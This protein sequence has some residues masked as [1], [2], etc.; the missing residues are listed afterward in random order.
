MA[1]VHRE[2]SSG[3]GKKR[4][5]GRSSAVYTGRMAYACDRRYFLLAAGTIGLIQLSC[6]IE[7]W[8]FKF[9]RGFHHFW[10]VALVE[11][12]IF[13]LCGHVATARKLSQPILELPRK[14]SGP[15]PLYA[16]VGFCLAGGTGLGKLA[17][18]YL[19]Y[20]TGTILKSMKLLP[21]LMLSACWL[22]RRFHRL[23]VMASVLM[24]GSAA[25]FGLGEREVEP[26]FHPLGLVL[27]LLGLFAQAVQNAANDRILRDHN[28]GVHEAMAWTNFFG[29][30]FTLL[31]CVANGELASGLLFFSRSWWYWLALVVRC[32]LFYAGALL[33]TML[34]KDSGAVPAVFVTTMRKALTVVVSFVLFPK[35]WSQNYA[36]GSVL[37]L[38][39]IGCEHRGN[40]LAKALLAS[41]L[42]KGVEGSCFSRLDRSSCDDDSSLPSTP[43]HHSG[44][45][46]RLETDRRG[47]GPRSSSHAHRAGGAGEEEEG[48]AESALLREKTGSE[49]SF[50]SQND[51]LA[52]DV[53][54]AHHPRTPSSAR[55][56]ACA[57]ASTCSS[58]YASAAS[59]A[60]GCAQD[61][62]EPAGREGAMIGTA[63]NQPSDAHL[64]SD[65][66]LAE[67]RAKLRPRHH[68]GNTR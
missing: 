31:L 50:V 57:R 20:A 49:A 21:T 62:D 22:R 45:A 48:E 14:P 67:L 35:P 25:L 32:L 19:N 13:S 65:A 27:S 17:Y 5:L 51:E 54:L 2:N 33:Y 23:Q 12:F 56:A 43:Y 61:E 7:E 42:I 47:G 6:M 28:D 41:D 53:Q 24:V 55:T 63:T 46:D 34:L 1:C 8:I 52:E 11:L 26:E 9:M 60:S 68:A 3:R 30:G 66:Q 16:I 64:A 10:F 40:A 39:A 36:T 15:L 29:F 59:A 18:K 44:G 4:S 38:A 37:L 58:I